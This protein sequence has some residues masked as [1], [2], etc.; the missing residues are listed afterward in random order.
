MEPI[1]YQ[2]VGIELYNQFMMIISNDNPN[3]LIITPGSD[4]ELDYHFK[5][6]IIEITNNI[7][8]IVPL[9]KI[10]IPEASYLTVYPNKD[11]FA[12]L[13]LR[14]AGRQI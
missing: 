7:R 1:F 10:E 14:F 2:L 12:L 11:E 5:S 3:I 6:D 4:F 9:I 13:K 8:K